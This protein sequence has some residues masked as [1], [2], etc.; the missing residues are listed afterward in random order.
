ML[1]NKNQ[2]E[3]LK[4]SRAV[5]QPLLP[6]YYKGQSGKVAVIGGC[7]DYTG[8]PFFACHSAALVGSDLSHVVCEK[9]AAPVIKGY[10]PDLMVHPYLYELDNPEVQGLDKTPLSE[11][12]KPD[13][14]DFDGFIEQKV[15]PKVLGII[16]RCDIFVIGPG[17]GRDCLMMRTVIKIIE[18]IKVMNKPMILDADALYLVS[19]DPSIVKHYKKAILTPNMVEFDRIGAKLG[20]SS[21]LTERDFTKILLTTQQC[22]Q[23]LGVTIIGKNQADL[24]VDQDTYLMNNTK[25]SNRRVGG[26]G[27]TLTGCLAVF[28]NWATHYQEEFWDITGPKLSPQESRLLACFAASMLVRVAT[29]KAYQKYGRAL[30]TSKVHEYLGLAYRELFE[31]EEFIKL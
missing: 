10:S 1:G 26:Q 21:I 16:N 4:L 24:I 2:K 9:R 12:I 23:K 14:K 25:G 22:S 11:V 5:V 8:A 6:N 28:V 13:F 20:M 3:L 15:M 30:Q 31:S 17:M 27:D 7:E 29:N 19:L 18:Q